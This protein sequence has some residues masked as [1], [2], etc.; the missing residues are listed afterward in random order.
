MSGSVFLGMQA[1]SSKIFNPSLDAELVKANQQ[2]S[3]S[4]GEVTNRLHQEVGKT[5]LVTDVLVNVVHT[6]DVPASIVEEAKARQVSTPVVTAPT[7]KTVK[8]PT[9]PSTKTTPPTATVSAPVSG[10]L[11]RSLP[12]GIDYP[13]SIWDI[14]TPKEDKSTQ[15]LTEY[16]LI[17]R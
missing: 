9:T 11:A 5:A 17:V 4:L 1:L 6:G 15:T 7:T 13:A 3:S 12:T 14:Q 16:I 8:A 10:A 2:L